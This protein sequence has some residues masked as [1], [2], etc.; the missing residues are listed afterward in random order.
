MDERELPAPVVLH[1]HVHL[2]VVRDALRAVKYMRH[3]RRVFPGDP[4]RVVLAHTPEKP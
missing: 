1:A 4:C 2:I 3:G